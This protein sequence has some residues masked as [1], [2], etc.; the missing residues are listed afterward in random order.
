MRPRRNQNQN[1]ALPPKSRVATG[2][3]RRRQHCARAHAAASAILQSCV[4]GPDEVPRILDAARH[5]DEAVGDPDL[6]PVLL[7]HVRVRH[8]RAGRDDALRRAQVLAEA[9]GPLA[10]VHQ[11]RAG[12]GTPD[13]VEPEHAAV[14]VV[15][16]LL[17]RERLLGEGG[18]ARVD[19]P[20]DLGVLLE[21]LRDV[22]G[23]LGLLLHPEGHGLG[24][25]QYDERRE[26]VHDVP[27]HVLDPLDLL[28]ELL[29]GGDDGAA[30]H[31]VVPLVVLRQALDHHVGAVVDGP[32]HDGRREGRVA[33]VRGAV[34]LRDLRDPLEV[35]Q[36][37][38][39]IRG[40]LR[41]DELRVRLH[42]LAHVLVVSHVYERELHAQRREELPARP[43]RAAVGAV[44]DDT[45]IPRLH[46][47]ADGAGRRGH[48]GTKCTCTN[49]ALNEGELRLQGRHSRVVRARVA[50]PLVQVFLD[51]LL[52]ERG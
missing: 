50:V 1:S 2:R 14:Q 22:H 9:P 19:D 12:L 35:G 28:R 37:Q 32:A 44:G 8:D 34:L 51:R 30:G 27:V 33:D 26:G 17:V 15:P 42:R 3:L 41:E 52:H 49:S 5:P 40:A 39:W 25:L 31:H 18:Q 13:D 46:R 47:C 38:H 36:R 24:R 4:Q 48:A 7:Q 21:E 29:R 10:R 6:E 43:V 45:V 16:V 11:A 23:V 20:G